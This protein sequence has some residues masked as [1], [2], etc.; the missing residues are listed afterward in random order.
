MNIREIT[1]KCY[2]E[3]AAFC[4]YLLIIAINKTLR[5]KVSGAD[6][7]YALK[8][9]GRKMVFIFWHQATFIPLYHYRNQK[10]CLLT[11]KSIKGEVLAR[12]CERLG[13]Q[14]TRLESEDDSKGFRQ[15]LNLA[16]Q[17][18]DCNI[19]V[20]G[21]N[22]PIYKMKPGAL[23]LAQKLGWPVLPV[24]VAVHPRWGI[25]WR[26]DKY[27]IPWPFARAVILFGDPV[28][29]NESS[30]DS[31]KER[32]GKMLIGLTLQAEKEFID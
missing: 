4:F 26:W 7:F 19:A 5:I 2:I 23:F 28:Y 29:V 6:K 16:K 30:M 13:Y 12:T 1:A 15:M 10:A 25:P 17:G 11:M 18:Y 21:P 32:R 20:D 9:A 8:A 14:V 24:A 3:F 27:L 22:G 31:E